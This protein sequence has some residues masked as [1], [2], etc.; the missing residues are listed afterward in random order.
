MD[1]LHRETLL[2][3]FSCLTR[4]CQKHSYPIATRIRQT[5]FIVCTMFLFIPLLAF[6]QNQNLI[7]NFK[8]LQSSYRMSSAVQIDSFLFIAGGVDQSWNNMK[9][10]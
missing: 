5:V 9:Y 1:L 3:M 2:S 6:S 10:F 8:P 4:C 7:D